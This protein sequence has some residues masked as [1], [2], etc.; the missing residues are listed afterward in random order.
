MTRAR[1]D[2]ARQA[3]LQRDNFQRAEAFDRATQ[4]RRFFLAWLQALAFK[5]QMQ[6]RL[7]LLVKQQHT[8]MQRDVLQVWRQYCVRKQNLREAAGRD[9]PVPGMSV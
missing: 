2:A 6:Q 1:L 5:L 3:Q 9:S 8:R 7:F 4:L